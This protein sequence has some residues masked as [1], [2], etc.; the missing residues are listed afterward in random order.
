MTLFP[1]SAG[2]LNDYFKKTTNKAGF[3][4]FIVH[5]NFMV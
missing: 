2:F 4:M 3:H 1:Q 5:E